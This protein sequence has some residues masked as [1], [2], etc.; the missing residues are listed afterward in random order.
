MLEDYGQKVLGSGGTHRTANAAPIRQKA[1][2]RSKHE[3]RKSQDCGQRLAKGKCSKGEACSFKHDM[4]K[5]GK[6]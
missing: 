1:E 4:N 3:E 2:D 5:K 6:G